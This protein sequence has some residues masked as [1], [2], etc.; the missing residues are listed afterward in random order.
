MSQTDVLKGWYMW[1]NEFLKVSNKHAP[2]VE[3]RLK[4]RNNPW[5]APNIVKLMYRRDFLHKRAVTLK[6]ESAWEEYKNMRNTVNR[7]VNIRKRNNDDNVVTLNR[8]EPKIL[9]RK[10]NDLVR[11]KK[12]SNINVHGISASKFNKYFSTIGNKVSSRFPKQGV[13]KWKNPPPIFSFILRYIDVA[14]VHGDLRSLDG[15]SSNDVLQ[16]DAKLLRMSADI[17]C[18]TLTHFYNIS[19]SSKIIP[20]EWK[21][22]RITPIYKGSE[23]VHRETNYRPISVLSHVAKIFERNVHEQIVNYLEHHCFITPYQSAYPEKHSTVTCL[24]RVIDDMCENID[25]GLVCGVCFLDIEKCFDTIDHDIL[26]QILRWYGI[27]GQEL[28]WF[29]NYLYDRKQCVRVDNI[30]SDVTS[31]PIGVPQGSI[32]GPI[33]FLLHVNDF[34]QY[35][36]NQNCNIFADDAMNY[37]FGIDIPETESKLQCALNRL[38]PWYSANRLSISAQKSAVMLIGKKSQVKHANLAVSINGDLLEQVC[39]TKYLGVTV[40][41]HCHGTVN[42]KICVAS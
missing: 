22:A 17:I 28:D 3:R 9:W 18:R 35:I 13:R 14:S 10:I 5:I 33:L 4:S 39:S 29:K 2:I 1:K 11:E 38:T 26:L 34:A 21:L 42:V 23:D 25:D 32:L 15:D 41:V 40:T 36:D 24:H 37:S 27:D 20:G 30:T 8:N 6:D 7:E 16:L 12:S 31:C 19:L